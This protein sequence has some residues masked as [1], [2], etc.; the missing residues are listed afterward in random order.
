MVPKG[1]T[2]PSASHDGYNQNDARTFIQK[3]GSKPSLNTNISVEYQTHVQDI[4][5]QNVKE[6]WTA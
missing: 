2:A 6:K 5:W 3:S 4:G 1:D